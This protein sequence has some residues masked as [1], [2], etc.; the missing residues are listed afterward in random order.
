MSRILTDH[1]PE[2]PWYKITKGKPEVT[3]S[4]LELHH[5]RVLRI[6]NESK[7]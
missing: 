7:Y 4:K 5:E 2:P 1:V 3:K 6:V